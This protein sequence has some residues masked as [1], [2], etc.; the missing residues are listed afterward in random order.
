MLLEPEASWIRIDSLSG[1]FVPL[2]SIKIDELLG[3]YGKPTATTDSRTLVDSTGEVTSFAPRYCVASGG[4]TAPLVEVGLEFIQGPEA[5]GS[6]V[7]KRV[8]VSGFPVVPQEFLQG[9]IDLKALEAANPGIKRPNV[10]FRLVNVLMY[11]FLRR[12]SRK[13]GISG[14]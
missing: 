6:L 5:S 4:D 9:N 11:F 3:L 12:S 10:T 1:S 13:S 14:G 8:N 2:E 7:F